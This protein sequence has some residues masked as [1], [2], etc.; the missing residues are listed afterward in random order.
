MLTPVLPLTASSPAS[1]AERLPL[2]EA[3]NR[4]PV[5]AESRD[6]Y[7]RDAFRHHWNTGDDPSDGCNTRA[8]GLLDEAVEQPTVG[9]RCATIARLS[10]LPKAPQSH[11]E[12]AEI[13]MRNSRSSSLVA[14]TAN[15]AFPRT[16]HAATGGPNPSRSSMG[17]T[18]RPR[19]VASRAN[20]SPK[21]PG[22]AN[23]G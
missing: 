8:E 14:Y 16:R 1:A 13:S 6:G 10:V 12:S 17:P 22:A 11:P 7:D 5:E 21:P 2:S 15:R 23:S 19:R 9:S 3:V 18:A 4:L 20:A